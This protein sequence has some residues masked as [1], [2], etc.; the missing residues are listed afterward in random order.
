M[1]LWV[2][3]LSAPPAASA[4]EI[5]FGA[6]QPYNL[7]SGGNNFNNAPEN[8]LVKFLKTGILPGG[9][10]LEFLGG[11]PRLY[12]QNNRWSA[13][14]AQSTFDRSACR[15]LTSLIGHISALLNVVIMLVPRTRTLAEGV[16]T[17]Q[18]QSGTRFRHGCTLP[19]LAVD[20]SEM[21]LKPTSSSYMI[22]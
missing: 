14:L 7:T 13:A 6:F 1:Q 3:G 22:L 19:P 5:E 10:G 16:S 4:D 17:L 21:D 12:A 18:L 2:W 15:S 8:Q 20:T 11:L 9:G